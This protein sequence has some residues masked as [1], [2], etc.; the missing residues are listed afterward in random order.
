MNWSTPQFRMHNSDQT[1]NPLLNELASETDPYQFVVMMNKET[2]KAKGL[3]DGDE[4]IVEAYWG[5]STRGTL[6]VTSLIHPDAVG[7]PGIQGFKSSHS[8]PI[9]QR[10]PNFNSL[11]NSAE[12]TFDPL[13]GGIDRNPRVRVH[14]AAGG[15]I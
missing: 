4:V 2:A 13:H 15:G 7:I 10:G 8:N 3:V 6:K 12:G 5:G 1:G 14:P 9:R 11:L